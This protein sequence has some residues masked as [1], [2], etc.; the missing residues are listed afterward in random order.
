MAPAW[1]ER[2]SPRPAGA[3][4]PWAPQGAIR[5]NG[6]DLLQRYG[7]FDIIAALDREL[8]QHVLRRSHLGAIEQR[9]AGG[10]E[11]REYQTARERRNLISATER[12]IGGHPKRPFRCA[13]V[14]RRG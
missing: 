13:L 3:L 6:F 7:R 10:A 8:C 12:R 4:R 14:L 9:L 1:G 5:S 2:L 11:T